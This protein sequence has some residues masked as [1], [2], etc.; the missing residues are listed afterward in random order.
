MER[1]AIFIDGAY[2]AAVLRE[3]FDTTPVDFRLL[4]QK[5]SEGRELLRAYYYNCLPY[6]GN[7]PTPEQEE[8]LMKARTFF[9]ALKRIPRFEIREGEM[10]FRGYDSETQRP[11]FVQKRVD[12]LMTLDLLNLAFRRAISYAAI[13]TGDSDFVPVLHAVKSEG[14]VTHLVHGRFAHE[15]LIDVADEDTPMDFEFIQD[16][17]RR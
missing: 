17:S 12:T 3:E 2:F 10:E 4:I 11:I 13:L 6:A 7:S 16:I 14:V 5:L 8:R 9:H 15:G 1:M